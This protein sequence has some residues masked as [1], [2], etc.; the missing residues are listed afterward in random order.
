MVA[1]ANLLEWLER[2]F[3]LLMDH[4]EMGDVDLRR[5]RPEVPFISAPASFP[6]YLPL[7]SMT[8]RES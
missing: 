8:E 5:L 1:S 7:P 4:G 6:D 3:T 2:R